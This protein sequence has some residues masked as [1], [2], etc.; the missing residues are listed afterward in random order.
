MRQVQLQ[1]GDMLCLYS[2]GLSEAQRTGTDGKREL[3]GMKRMKSILTQQHHAEAAVQRLL[4]A[5]EGWHVED[6]LTLVLLQYR[7]IR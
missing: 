5:L 6:D 4:K 7:P 1:P 3:F 2:D